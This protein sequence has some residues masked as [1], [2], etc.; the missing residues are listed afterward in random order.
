MNSRMRV[1][2]WVLLMQSVRLG[3]L[4]TKILNQSSTWLSFWTMLGGEVKDNSLGWGHSRRRSELAWMWECPISL[5]LHRPTTLLE[6]LRIFVKRLFKNNAS[7]SAQP[8][9]V[10][11]LLP[12]SA[13]NTLSKEQLKQA[14]Q[15]ARESALQLGV[16]AN[17]VTLIADSVSL[18]CNFLFRISRTCHKN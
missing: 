15:R 4:G 7:Q 1:F 16:D 2:N 8:Q 14:H 9:Y 3:N 10:Q 13:E 5:W 11:L 6:K 17:K 12:L 18:V